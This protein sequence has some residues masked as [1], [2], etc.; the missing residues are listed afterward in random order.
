MRLM[1]EQGD[2]VFSENGRDMIGV[3]TGRSTLVGIQDSVD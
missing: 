1:G 2:Y 3:E